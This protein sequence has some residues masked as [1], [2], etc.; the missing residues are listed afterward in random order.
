[1]PAAHYELAI[2]DEAVG[3]PVYRKIKQLEVEDSDNTAD[4]FVIRLTAMRQ[5]SGVWSF[6][7]KDNFQ[8]FSKVRVSASFPDRNTEYLIE[9]YVTHIDFHIDKDETKSYVDISGI[10]STL[11]MNL[12]EKPVAWEDKSDS[13]IAKEIFDKYGFDSD[14]EDTTSATT[15]QSEPNFTTIQRETDIE[16]LKRLAARTGFDCFIKKDYDKNKTIGYSRKRKL[17]LRPQKD[18]AVQFG[19]S[20]NNVESMDFTVDALR[21]LSVEIRQKDPLLKRSRK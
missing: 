16:F 8:L 3:D 10:D 4:S 12:Q 9:G 2:N 20:N 18:L 14:I 11:L 17:D 21:P 6:P 13:E 5:R 1:L 7:A 15:P 19:P